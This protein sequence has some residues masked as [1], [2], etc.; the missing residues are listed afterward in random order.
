MKFFSLVWGNLWRRKLRTILTI[1]ST[2]A[3]FLL[4][5]VLGAVRTGFSAGV[6]VSGADRLMVT[7]KVSIIMQ[8]PISYQDRIIAVPGVEAVTHASW[9]GGI[10]QEPKNFFPQMAV[11]PET[12]L[13]L[14]PEIRLKPEQKKA[15]LADR[16]GAIVGRTTAE[17]FGWKLGARIPIQPTIYRRKDGSKTWD[18]NIDGIYDGAEQG[19]DTTGFFFRYDYL[20]EAAAVDRGSVGWYIIRIADPKRA[21]DISKTIDG[22]FAN[23]PEETKTATE[24]AMAQ[25]F[26]NQVG[27]IGAMMTAIVSA[28][29]FT[30]LLVVGNT[31]A[32]AVR[33]RTGE[34]AVLKTLGFKQH[35]VLGLVLIESCAVAL[36]GGGLGLLGAFAVIPPLGKALR[37]FVPVFYLPG[38]DVAVAVGLMLLLG[39]AAGLPPA[40]TAMRLRIVDALR[41]I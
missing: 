14:Y 38:R 8:L 27:N 17:R 31:M 3:A 40:I 15:W 1:A 13:D 20:K 6:E 23:S 41:R 4:F 9:F 32:L 5:G 39:L 11:D 16:T 34:L 35:Q 37:Q 18:F 7:H 2:I 22:M 10:Y 24:K 26:A 33:E 12:Y 19:T 25:G 21:P 36:L 28:V 30:L 29:L